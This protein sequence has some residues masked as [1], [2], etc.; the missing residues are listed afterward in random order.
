[1]SAAVTLLHRGLTLHHLFPSVSLHQPKII[2]SL[3][4]Y[5]FWRKVVLTPP[6]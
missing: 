5:V 2:S 4:S 1:M 6:R 3:S